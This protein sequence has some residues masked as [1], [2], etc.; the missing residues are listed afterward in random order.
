[1]TKSKGTLDERY[2]TWLHKMLEPDTQRNPARSHWLLCAAM[3]RKEFTWF[4]P[5]DDNRG[6]DGLDLRYQFIDEEEGSDVDGMWQSQPCSFLEMVIA[7]SQRMAFETALESDYWFWTIMDNLGLRAYV[8]DRFGGTAENEVD[9]IL[10][11]VI[12]RTYHADGRGGLFP[13][14]HPGHDQREVEIWYQMSQFLLE[15]ITV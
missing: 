12:Q 3:F 1:M 11:T 7:L 9:Y 6:Y 4:I 10:N 8:D 14:A 5:N 15:T 13:L 2:L